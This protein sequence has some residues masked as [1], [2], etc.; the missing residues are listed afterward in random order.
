MANGEWQ[1]TNGET[2]SEAELVL[3]RTLVSPWCLRLP[4]SD[5]MGDPEDDDEEEEEKKKQQEEDDEE[6]EDNEG[7]EV[8]VPWQVR[9]GVRRNAG[10]RR[11]VTSDW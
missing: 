6:D 3:L 9:R 11:T 7:E 10:A 8:E 4:P 2:M 5:W 1:M